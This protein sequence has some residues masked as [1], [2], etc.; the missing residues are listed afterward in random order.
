MGLI[1]NSG[2]TL[3]NALYITSTD[4]IDTRLVVQYKSDL[5]NS[6]TW[7]NNPLHHGIIVSVVGDSTSDNGVYFLRL[8]NSY[9]QFGDPGWEK[10]GSGGCQFT[11]EDLS[12]QFSTI[13]NKYSITNPLSSQ[14]PLSVYY[15]GQRQFDNYHIEGQDLVLDGWLLKDSND[16]LYVVIGTDTPTIPSTTPN[17]FTVQNY[18]QSIPLDDYD[19]FDG[20]PSANGAEIKYVIKYGSKAKFGTVLFN[21]IKGIIQDSATYGDF[22]FAVN[23]MYNAGKLRLNNNTGGTVTINFTIIYI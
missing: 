10:V 2:I 4:P 7:A 12:D 1:Y 11:I 13:N 20:H 19:I 5:T 18:T 17:I 3:S 16:K 22:D 15:N 14:T 23:W 8:K 21:K 9:N 6:A